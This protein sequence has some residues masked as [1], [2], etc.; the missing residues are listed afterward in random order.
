VVLTDVT[1]KQLFLVATSAYETERGDVETVW[2]CAE[3]TE[4]G[5]QVERD[6]AA[7]RAQVTCVNAAAARALGGVSE[8]YASK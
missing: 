2:V 3:A 7:E 8:K 5:W 4:N 6:A 1:R